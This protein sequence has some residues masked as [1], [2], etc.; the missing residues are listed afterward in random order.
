M[1]EKDTFQGER[2]EGA[3]EV[4][5]DKWRPPGMS[6]HRRR[7][8]KRAEGNVTWDQR[9]VECIRDRLKTSI[10]KIEIVKLNSDTLQKKNPHLVV[11]RD[12]RT[13]IPNKT[14]ILRPNLSEI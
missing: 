8:D 9:D 12:S 10:D 6:D 13:P 11:G 2:H 1:A 5:L 7:R 3:P 4:G 14:V